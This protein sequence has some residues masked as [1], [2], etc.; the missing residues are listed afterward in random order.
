MPPVKLLT[1]LLPPILGSLQRNT[2]IDASLA[3]LLRI[4]HSLSTQ[5]IPIL[6][7]P[8]L[9]L[10]LASTL[11]LLSASHT[12]PPTRHIT[13]RLL[14]QVL[15]L[16]PPP[17]NMSFLSNALSDPTTPPPLRIAAVGLVKDAVLRALAS[18]S[19]NIWASPVALQTLAPLV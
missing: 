7:S 18:P 9:A 1:A 14:S 15:V 10:P 2:V 4:L 19:Q 8:E 5:P 12:H 17:L 13:F 16:M 3:S 6:L 11:S